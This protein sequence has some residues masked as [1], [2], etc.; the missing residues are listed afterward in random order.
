[1]PILAVEQ[2]VL[3]HTLVELQALHPLSQLAAA[4]V[5]VDLQLPAVV[6]HLGEVTIKI[7]EVEAQLQV[8]LAEQLDQWVRVL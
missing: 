8:Q 1:V 2:M 7:L 5:E 6:D 3:T 4:L